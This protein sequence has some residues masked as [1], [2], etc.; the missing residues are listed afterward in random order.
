MVSTSIQ[1]TI[2]FNKLDSLIVL[3]CLGRIVYGAECE[4]FVQTVLSG[5]ADSNAV[6]LDLSQTRALD[7][8][9]VGS[10]A[11]LLTTAGRN[12]KQ[13]VIVAPSPRVQEVLH[14]TK[15]DT[16]FEIYRDVDEALRAIK[17]SDW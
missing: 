8:A 1:L 9:G 12:H 15:M 17:N 16:V 10:L 7:S 14:L 2:R 5:L 6:A 11:R 4:R 3:V 13:L